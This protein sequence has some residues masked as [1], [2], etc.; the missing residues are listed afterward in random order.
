MDDDERPSI[1]SHK[2]IQANCAPLARYEISRADERHEHLERNASPS[3]TTTHKHLEENASLVLPFDIAAVHA[4]SHESMHDKGGFNVINGENF[5]QG[6]H[7][8]TPST[9]SG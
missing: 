1:V 2:H 6:Q 7:V 5:G 8:K 9:V 3:V 4:N